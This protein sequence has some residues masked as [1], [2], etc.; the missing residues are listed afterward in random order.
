MNSIINIILKYDIKL[1]LLIISL[2][3]ITLLLYAD[4]SSEPNLTSK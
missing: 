1:L 4:M 3:I 2:S